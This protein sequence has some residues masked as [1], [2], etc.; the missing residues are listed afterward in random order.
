MLHAGEA[1]TGIEWRHQQNFTYALPQLGDL[2]RLC[3]KRDSRSAAGAKHIGVSRHQYRVQFPLTG[4]RAV[5]DGDAV[6][7]R[8]GVIDQQKIE[9]LL[10]LDDREGRRRGVRFPHDVASVPQNGRDKSQHTPVIITN[11]DSCMARL[12]QR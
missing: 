5:Y 10:S 11:H 3:E 9:R 2:E 7:F 6:H 1:E 4:P 8:H 12:E